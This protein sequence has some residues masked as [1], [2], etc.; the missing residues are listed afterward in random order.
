MSLQGARLWEREPSTFSG[1]GEAIKKQLCRNGGDPN[2]KMTITAEGAGPCKAVADM[3]YFSGPANPTA[4]RDTETWIVQYKCPDAKDFTVRKFWRTDNNGPI[5]T[6]TREPGL[7]VRDISG[8]EIGKMMNQA[9]QQRPLR[10]ASSVRRFDRAL[11]GAQTEAPDASR[12]AL[13]RASH[14]TR[15]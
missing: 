14:V 3:P 15:A 7:V 2:K 9:R 12:S 11:L 8:T 13:H 10:R 1:L 4:A 5:L 6:T